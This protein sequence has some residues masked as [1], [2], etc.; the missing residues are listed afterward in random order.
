M[1][2]ANLL[3]VLAG[4]MLSYNSLQAGDCASL[5]GI[6]SNDALLLSGNSD[7]LWMLSYE[8]PDRY[9]VNTISG[10]G[11]LSVKITDESNWNALYLCNLGH[12]RTMSYAKGLTVVVPLYDTLQEP[13][14]LSVI[15]RSGGKINNLSV[16]FDWPT[17]IIQNENMRIGAVDVTTD[18]KNFYF[19]CLDAGVVQWD[20]I[21]EKMSLIQV[22]K[23]PTL[24]DSLESKAKAPENRVTAVSAFKTGLLVTTPAKIYKYSFETKQ[25]DSTLSTTIDR[26]GYALS[27]FHSAFINEKA[28]RSP[29]YSFVA[30]KGSTVGDDSL[31]L[32]KYDS[33]AGKWRIFMDNSPECITTGHNGILYMVSDDNQLEAYVD[34]AEAEKTEPN[35]RPTV[36]LKAFQ[37]S[38]TAAY[39]IEFPGNIND[40]LYSAM[41]DSTGNLW[42]ATTEGLFI[43]ENVSPGKVIRS[44]RLLKRAPSVSSGLEKTYARPGILKS[45]LYDAKTSRSVLVYNLSKDAKVTIRIYDYNMDHVK[46]VISGKFR[47]AGSN[48]GP[49]GR[50]T[51]ETEDFWDGKN[52]NGKIVAPGVYYYKISTDSGERA[53]GKLVVAK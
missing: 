1:M 53:F 29:L 51:V 50:S 27:S 40:I 2:R 7:T 8:D 52:E 45:G 12:I 48:G 9:A 31:V 46:T 14:D 5:K 10:D 36:G 19:A 28:K 39:K 43:S 11:N 17:R 47:K 32:C 30:V 33:I 44:C 41:S 3:L 15:V 35:P 6:A 38:M 18:Q 13:K 22:G 23:T 26:S 20:P 34:T 16:A 37:D 42:I 21:T 24:L 49:F 25:W 4:V